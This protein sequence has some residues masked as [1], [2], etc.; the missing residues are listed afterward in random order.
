MKPTIKLQHYDYHALAQQ[1]KS[2]SRELGFQFVGITDA[3]LSDYSPDFKKWLNHHFNGDMS[4][5][6]ENHEKRL[7]PEKLL[8]Q[9]IRIISVGIN[10]YSAMKYNH[11]SQHA[12]GK[13]YHSLIRKRL[14]K[15]ADKII[16]ITG[17]MTYRAFCDSAPVLEKPLAEKAGIGWVGKNCTLITKEL[18]SFVFLGELFVDLPLPID[19]PAEN[20]CGD[21]TKCLEACP[22]KA[23]VAPYQIDARKCI[24]Y[25]T[26]EHRGEIS[27]SLK[28][29]M[30]NKIVG[31][32]ICQNV[33]P[34]NQRPTETIETAFKPS[35]ELKTTPL[36]RLSAW[37]EKEFLEKTKASDIKRLGYERWQRNIKIALENLDDTEV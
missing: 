36:K 37:T 4:F 18:G 6:L 35:D 21:C 16:E 1:I 15:L 3:D 30:Q 25:L 14:Q 23:L 7:A 8:P 2:W 32:D 27:E 22:T 9:T 20:R 17:P 12:K 34:Y 24:A 13:D 31:C 33:C 28:K 29:Q 19:T 11:I 10:Y 5:M 26:I